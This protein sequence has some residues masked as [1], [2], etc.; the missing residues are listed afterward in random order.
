MVEIWI[1]QLPSFEQHG[2]CSVYFKEKPV[3]NPGE[4]GLHAGV[5]L[6]F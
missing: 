3:S 2:N 6:V 4:I 5:F 1:E